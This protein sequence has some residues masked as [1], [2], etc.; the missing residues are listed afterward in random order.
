M[1]QTL[2]ELLRRREQVIADHVW[3]DCEP[4]AHLEA[5]KE[6]SEAIENWRRE[7]EAGL[8]PRL[9]HFLENA[10]FAKALAFAAAKEGK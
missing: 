5:L 9:K 6:V 4:Q 3:R 1:N 7:H 8:D 10:S 2:I